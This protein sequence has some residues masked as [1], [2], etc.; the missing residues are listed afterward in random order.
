MLE[1]I[2][3][4]I[5]IRTLYKDTDSDGDDFFM[6]FVNGTSMLMVGYNAGHCTSSVFAVL[7]FYHFKL[8]VPD[9]AVHY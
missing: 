4:Q 5:K 2:R 7:L 9:I 6:L 8:Y 3:T 1:K